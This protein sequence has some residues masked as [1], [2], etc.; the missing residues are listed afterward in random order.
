MLLKIGCVKNRT[1]YGFLLRQI[2]LD[3]G[4]SEYRSCRLDVRRAREMMQLQLMCCA[5]SNFSSS[6]FTKGWMI[7]TE[8][9]EGLRELEGVRSKLIFKLKKYME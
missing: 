4:V 9:K 2:Q 1:P 3:Y 8:W 5:L 6:Q 7:V